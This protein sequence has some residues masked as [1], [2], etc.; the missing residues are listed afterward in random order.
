[1]KVYTAPEPIATGKSL[2]M[3]GGITG[4]WNWQTVLLDLIKDLDILVYNPRRKEWNPE[5]SS[6]E[7]ITWEWDAL[8]CASGISFWFSNETLQPITLLELGRWTYDAS[9][10]IFIGIDPDYKRREDVE[11]QMRL[12]MPGLQIVYS[13]EELAEQ[14]VSYY[15]S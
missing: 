12:Q 10:K 8:R 4:C 13:L 11:I 2:F 7:Q 5:I 9:K 3:A 15:N 6:E 1:M 14:I